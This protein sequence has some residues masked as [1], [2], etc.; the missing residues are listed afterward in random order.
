MAIGVTEGPLAC[1]LVASSSATNRVSTRHGRANPTAVSVAPIATRADHGLAA[2][3]PTRID[4]ESEVER[5]PGRRGAGR[6][7]PSVTTIARDVACFATAQAR[8]SSSKSLDLAPQPTSPSYAPASEAP[9]SQP[10][11]E[12]WPVRYQRESSVVSIFLAARD[13]LGPER[14]RT[15]TTVTVQ[16]G[17][18][19]RTGH[20]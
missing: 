9:E 13:R 19:T 5:G 14:A 6:L 1:P 10:V 17:M 11:P 20:G 3:D 4:P 15:R 2:T 18:A 8:S 7:R 12:N 16:G